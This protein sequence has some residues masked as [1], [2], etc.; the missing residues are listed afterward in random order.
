[1]ADKFI[2][3]NEK[4]Y[5]TY[6]TVEESNEYFGASYGSEWE[7]ISDNQKEKLLVTATRVI[8]RKEYQGEKFDKNQPLKF[9]RVIYG[10]KTSDEVLTIACCEL[11]ANI[12]SD[13]GA[14]NSMSNIKSVSLGG[15][16][17]SFVDSGKTEC[18][19]DLIIERF[20]SDYLIGGIKVIL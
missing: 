12:Y 4:K 15:S 3:I 16:S 7:N 19:D 1:M 17:I 10:E 6:A 18:E 5:Y 11:A 2:I 13:G 20:L 9:P 14:D 8:D